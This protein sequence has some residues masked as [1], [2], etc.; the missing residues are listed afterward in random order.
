MNVDTV[1]NDLIKGT[2]TIFSAFIKKMAL[3]GRASVEANAPWMTERFNLKTSYQISFVYFQILTD[4]LKPGRSIFYSTFKLKIGPDILPVRVQFKLYD[5]DTEDGYFKPSNIASETGV[6]YSKKSTW[7]IIMINIRRPALSKSNFTKYMM[8]YMLQ[9]KYTI[10]HELGHAYD[11]WVD[12]FKD[13]DSPSINSSS[14]DALKYILYFLNPSELS[15]FFKEC[16]GLYRDE[17]KRMKSKANRRKTSLFIKNLVN[18]RQLEEYEDKSSFTSIVARNLAARLSHYD[19]QMQV[20]NFNLIAL[21]RRLVTEDL[22]AHKMFIF[23]YVMLIILPRSNYKHL[24]NSRDYR[25]FVAA[26]DE[27]SRQYYNIPVKTR[28]STVYRYLTAAVYRLSKCTN[29]NSAYYKCRQMICDDN[30][31]NVLDNPEE[32]KKLLDLSGKL[33]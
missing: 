12:N 31:A 9:L 25:N 27:I 8:N 10:L 16:I 24:I 20:D 6:Y 22:P 1:D 17:A 30:L 4:S 28:L 18:T 7:P 26:Q 33:K 3:D 5:G 11:Y 32:T 23:L 19:L 2:N 15:S 29:K 21:Y 14:T 13:L